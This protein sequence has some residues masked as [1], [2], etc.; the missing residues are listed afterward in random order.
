MANTQNSTISSFDSSPEFPPITIHRPIDFPG[1][2][3]SE[4]LT[5]HPNPYPTEAYSSPFQISTPVIITP[6]EPRA[7]RNGVRLNQIRRI[8]RRQESRAIFGSIR[9][10]LS[11]VSFRETLPEDRI[12]SP[13]TLPRSK[14]VDKTKTAIELESP[15]RLQVMLS[16]EMNKICLSDEIDSTNVPSDSYNSAKLREIN[17]LEIMDSVFLA[18]ESG[19]E[20]EISNALESLEWNLGQLMHETEIIDKIV[21]DFETER[22]EKKKKW[23]EVELILN[24]IKNDNP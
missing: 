23:D 15:N 16:E 10:R 12:A 11:M 14:I 1:T 2:P 24:I 22:D 8:R 7:V 5:P 20:E 17:R 6:V 3:T 18:L 9:R 13:Q 4:V 19:C 21:E